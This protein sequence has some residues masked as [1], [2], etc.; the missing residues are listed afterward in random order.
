M[1]FECP[2]CGEKTISLKEK[3]L[4]G[5]WLTRNCPNCNT[6]ISARPIPLAVMYCIYTWNVMWF[7]ALFV[8]S[9]MQGAAD[10]SYLLYM[11]IGWI[12]LDII[13]INV[14]PLGAMKSKT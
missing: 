11:V 1:M 10:V 3:H 8:Y 5:Y 14:V 6:R 12:I 9:Y 13:N 2:Y 4:L 7:F